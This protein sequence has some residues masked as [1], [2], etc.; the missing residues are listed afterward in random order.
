M[1]RI[2]ITEYGPP[3]KLDYSLLQVTGLTKL[4]INDLILRA[5]MKVGKLLGFSRNP[6]TIQDEGIRA[7]KIAGIIRVTKGLELEIAPKYLGSEAENKNWREDFFYLSMLSRHG[8]LLVNDRLTAKTGEPV[9]LNTLLARSMIDLFWENHRRPLRTYNKH[10]FFDFAIE[11]D[12]DPEAI[13]FPES[14][15][16][17][18]FGLK[19]SKQNQFNNVI[20]SAAR[21][22]LPNV[23]DPGTARQ[24]ERV[25]QALHPQESLSIKVQK[26]RLP[27]RSS[28]WQ[29]LYDLSLD[30]LNGFGISYRSGTVQAPGYVLNS[31]IIWQDLLETAIRIGYGSNRVQP[32]AETVIGNRY[33]LLGDRI[34][35]SREA[36][37]TPDLIITDVA[38]GIPKL[39]IDAKYKGNFQHGNKRISEEDIYESV[40]FAIATECPIVLLLYPGTPS[41]D[42]TLGSLTPFEKVEIGEI[43]IIG[44]EVDITG[45]SQRDGLRRFSNHCVSEIRHV[46]EKW[47]FRSR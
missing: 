34:V 19:Y 5:G 17:Q 14:D 26:K 32:Q 39:I 45:I 40:A 4:Q 20:L 36:T 2:S 27:N 30:I 31:W 16:F 7:E 25:I 43:I 9:H 35:R 33:R 3:V 6:I 23:H 8:S 18:Q 12:A 47:S 21:Q 38:E 44:V 22:L 1:I 37:V 13:L 11:G 15:G 24:L 29:T 46:V 41:A 42:T 10:R 28:R